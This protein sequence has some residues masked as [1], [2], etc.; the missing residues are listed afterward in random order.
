MVLG[1]AFVTLLS[2][3]SHFA[4]HVLSAFCVLTGGKAQRRSRF[5]SEVFGFLGEPKVIYMAT[6]WSTQWEIPVALFEV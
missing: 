2:W 3:D 5:F 4:V 6:L 1:L